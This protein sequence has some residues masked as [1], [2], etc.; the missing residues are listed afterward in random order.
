M[1]NKIN[2]F[3]DF[4]SISN[5]LSKDTELP[6]DLDVDGSDP[7]VNPPIEDDD[8]DVKDPSSIED[9][10]KSKTDDNVGNEVK[11]ITDSNTIKVKVGNDTKFV[12]P[13]DVITDEGDAKQNNNNNSGS[14]DSK[15]TLSVVEPELAAYMQEKLYEKFGWDLEEGDSKF[16]SFDSIVE[17]VDQ[18]VATNSKPEFAST[19][20]ETLNEYIK[21]GGDI[22][23]YLKSRY[24]GNVDLNKLN[25]DDK[26]SQQLVLREYFNKQ[27]YSQ[28]KIEKRLR[29]YEETGLIGE[30]AQYA[31]DYLKNIREEDS[32]KL[33]KEQEITKKQYESDQLKLYN[34][35]V[36]YIDNITDINGMPLSQIEKRKLKE[37]ALVQDPQKKQT[38]YQAEYNNNLVRNFVN[39][40]YYTMV[41]DKF[42][43]K[44]NKKAETNATLALKKKLELS[45]KRGKNTNIQS[46]DDSTVDHSFFSRISSSLSK[47]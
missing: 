45:T 10:T 16:D 23:H 4:S 11:D 25:L 35:V 38:R 21:N 31:Y 2:T 39:S 26:I 30:E 7:I 6:K 22:E 41:G 27:G 12:D 5:F 24:A 20:L 33:L 36:S 43:T 19:E 34:D 14:I 47:P 13:S 17:F 9:G 37:F 8:Q 28:D 46:D 1:D 32:K 44:M 15:D 29:S 18:L 3:G 40:A 42:T